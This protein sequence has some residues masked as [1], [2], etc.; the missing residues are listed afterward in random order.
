MAHRSTHPLRS[1]SMLQRI[2]RST[3]REIERIALRTRLRPPPIA[4]CGSPMERPGQ[5]RHLP[6]LHG[7]HSG[8]KKYA[9]LTWC[10]QHGTPC[11]ASTLTLEPMCR[12]LKRAISHVLLGYVGPSYLDG[13]VPRGILKAMRLVRS[14]LASATIHML[15]VAGS[16]KAGHCKAPCRRRL[17]WV[18]WSHLQHAFT[19]GGF[20]NGAHC[21]DIIH[22]L[23]RRNNTFELVRADHPA[24]SRTGSFACAIRPYILAVQTRVEL[25]MSRLAELLAMDADA[26]LE[27]D[28][29]RRCVKQRESSLLEISPAVGEGRGP[30]WKTKYRDRAQNIVF[31]IVV[32]CHA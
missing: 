10:P 29:L 9:S 21:R 4:S 24:K 1:A 17:Q 5:D 18:Q 7:R 11:V 32:R 14:H 6:A 13:L 8:E 12:E 28:R 22:W 27:L 26:I 23:A 3:L 19:Q 20:L 16:S 15:V 25:E 30:A 2:S 31:A